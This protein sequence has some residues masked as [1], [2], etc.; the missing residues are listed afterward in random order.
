[1]FQAAA[2][3]SPNLHRVAAEDLHSWSAVS[4]DRHAVPIPV[5][6]LAASHCDSGE[7]TFST[8]SG[9]A[10]RGS[11]QTTSRKYDSAEV[12]TVSFLESSSSKKLN[13]QDFG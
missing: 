12:F 6:P 13:G 8:I 11:N 3:I 9:P 2:G 4:V 7:L 5:I 1:L 10:I